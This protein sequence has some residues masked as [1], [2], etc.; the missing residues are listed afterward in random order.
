MHV[1]YIYTMRT[2]I[3]IPASLRQKLV[4][5]AARQN[6][7]G[8]SPIIVNALKEYFEHHALSQTPAGLRALRGCLSEEEYRLSKDL[9]EAGRGEWKM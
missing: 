5:E 6:L 1:L 9:I 8:F 7:K 4:S 2:T 3:E